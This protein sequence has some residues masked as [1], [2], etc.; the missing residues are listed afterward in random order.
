MTGNTMKKKVSKYTKKK[1]KSG[2]KG[3]G[4]EGQWRKN[5]KE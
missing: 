4:R 5:K 2:E 1:E 3:K